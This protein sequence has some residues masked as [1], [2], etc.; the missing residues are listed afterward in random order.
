[1]PALSAQSS[2][3]TLS[4]RGQKHGKNVTAF[5][6]I[7]DRIIGNAFCH[8]TNP[9]GIVNMAIS[10]NYL[11]E[12]ELLT[13]FGAN[14]QM[15]P[16][17]LTYGTSLFG[18]HRLFATLCTL[19]NS[20]TFNPIK[21]ILS[22]H[23]I[24]GP[25]C[26]PLLDQLAEHLAEPG[27]A[28]LVA[29]PYYNGYDAD[30]ACRCE[31]KCIPVFSE[32]DDGT[33]SKNFEGKTAL[34][35]FELAKE[36][37]QAHNPENRIRAVIVCNPHNPV[38]RCYD[39]EALLEYGRFAEKHNLHLIFDEIFAMS[40]YRSDL[41]CKGQKPESF[42]SALSI[43][44]QKE[45]DCHPG[46]IH[47]IWSAS[48]D[49]GING[50]RVGTL[51]SQ[52]N[53]ALLRAMKA[54]AKL[55]M[56]SSPADAL[57]CALIDNNEVYNDFI[58]TNQARMAQAYDIVV[59]WCAYHSIK[60]VQCSAGHF[61]LIDLSRFLPKEVDGQTL[62]DESAREGAL[63]THFLQNAVCLTPG[64]NY[65]HPQLGMF[66][67]TFTLRRQALLEGLMRIENALGLPSWP[68]KDA[69]LL[70]R[71]EEMQTM[72]VQESK[73]V[74]SS[75]I[76]FSSGTQTISA[77]NTIDSELKPKMRGSSSREQFALSQTE[78]QAERQE[79]V[80]A[81]QRVLKEGGGSEAL[82]NCG[83]GMACSSCV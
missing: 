55:Y 33:G 42:H 45:A 46:R 5:W 72:K 77:A 48:K 14:L 65:H 50:L 47:V 21:P 82:L 4:A 56:V 57:F 67:L 39:R 16:T 69:C 34:R 1:M 71:E 80:D 58:R 18:S 52:G 79:Y 36:D 12:P 51:I 37:W 7:F 2:L 43:D 81:V 66:R 70:E 15:Q 26:G 53:P 61:I 28:M 19:F 64:S 41:E 83:M 9:H 59:R 44:W 22:Q 17:D 49:F 75:K 29:A 60:H 23:L 40:T 62:K 35:G 20:S 74:S 54:T 25:G 8:E 3:P 38:G 27:D 68:E 63:W 32:W 13:F 30:F 78:A 24:T 76:T 11:L 31:V 73:D 6:D 10:N